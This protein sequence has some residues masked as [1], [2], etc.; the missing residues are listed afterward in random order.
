MNVKATKSDRFGSF[1]S[2]V[3]TEREVLS[4]VNARF[5][6]L[7]Q[8]HGLT[9]DAVDGWYSRLMHQCELQDGVEHV[10]FLLQRISARCQAEAD[11]SRIVFDD[12]PQRPLPISDLTEE[13]RRAC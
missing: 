3:E 5:G 2:R 8:L 12:A 11:Q 10:R 9:L 4:I 6:Q 1:F 13:L 7:A